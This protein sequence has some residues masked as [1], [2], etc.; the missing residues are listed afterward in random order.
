M[1]LST[2]AT[3]SFS[4]VHDATLPPSAFEL[5]HVILD[6]EAVENINNVLIED[7]MSMAQLR[8]I[9]F[10]SRNIKRL[11]QELDYHY[12]EE[13]EFYEHVM[14]DEKFRNALQP[15]VHEYRRRTRAKG[16]HPYHNRPLT[17]PSLSASST[18][19]KG[20]SP[21]SSSSSHSDSQSTSYE[22]GMS[23]VRAYL[24]QERQQNQPGTSGNPIVVEATNDD[25]KLSSTS[26]QSS[27]DFPKLLP[28]CRR[29]HLRQ[30]LGR[31]SRKPRLED[32]LS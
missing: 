30:W 3:T 26:S 16:F 21:P 7:A 6:S 25:D 8:H 4:S 17:H 19:S 2:L 10:M 20:H 32:L 13:R 15:V 27:F 1:S 24:E 28:R 12:E 23:I 14:K 31:E 11:E 29:R 9:Y 5:R 22:S 18:S